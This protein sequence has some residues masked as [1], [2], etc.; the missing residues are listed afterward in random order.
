MNSPKRC[1]CGGIDHTRTTNK[2]CPLYEDSNKRIKTT[3]ISNNL[4]KQTHLT[5]I[6]QSLNCSPQSVTRTTILSSIQPRNINFND[7]DNAINDNIVTQATRT[8]LSITNRNKEN[9]TNLNNVQC[10][11]CKKIFKN[12]RTLTCHLS[13]G[14]CKMN[15]PI[16]KRCKHCN[17]D[18][19]ERKSS[20][21][22]PYNVRNLPI[23]NVNFNF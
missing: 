9:T 11:L 22:C 1:R 7:S 23:N 13:K 19:H 4:N 20:Y 16:I 10:T 8:A 5:P 18:T 12:N 14:Y 21:E 3:P 17:S 6:F 2:K 15:Q